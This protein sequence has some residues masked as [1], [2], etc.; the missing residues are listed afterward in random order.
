MRLTPLRPGVVYGTYRYR[1]RYGANEITGISERVFVDTPIRLEDRAHRR[2]QRAPRHAALRA[3]HH[4]RDAHR[5]PRRRADPERDGGRSRRQDRVRGQVRR[6]CRRR[7]RRRA[8]HVDHARTR[9]RAHA[10]LADRL[11]GRTSR[12]ARLCARSIRTKA[13]SPICARIP[14]RFARSYLCS[15]VTGVFDVGGYTWTTEL[16]KRLEHDTAAPHISAAGPLLS[17]LDHWLNLPAERQF[18][19]LKDEATARDGVR[20]LAAHGATR[21]QGLVPRRER[22]RHHRRGRSG[23]RREAP[24]DRARDGARRREGRGARGR[25]AARA[26]RLGPAGRRRIHR[27]R[28]AAGHD[29]HADAHGDGRL[30]ADVRVRGLPHTA[31]DRRS[32]SL[33][34]CRDARESR[35]D[36][37]GRCRHHGS[38]A[39]STRATHRRARGR[40]R[41]ES[42]ATRRRRHPDRDGHR[43]RQSAHAPRPRDLRGDGGDAESGHDADAGDR[44]VDR[45]RRARRALRRRHRH[46]R[47]RE[48]RG[49]PA[50][51]RRS[52][53]GRRRTSAR[54]GS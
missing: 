18:I 8:R 7:R 13:R 48:E 54:C 38:A 19:H 39:A 29:P 22:S 9:R 37:D 53:A 14:E 23:E 26:Q 12:R 5:R 21:D 33:R 1:V 25:E 45:H 47:E 44:R 6:S 42:Q 41:R 16:A 34:R 40:R 51:R 35:I 15:G 11:G 52:S 20:Y 32:E 50:A 28:E 17:T 27:P 36:R 24:A 46:D 2:D 49:P 10:L 3:R 30:R 31:R 43:R 4:R